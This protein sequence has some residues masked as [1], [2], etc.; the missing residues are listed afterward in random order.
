METNY[1][2]IFGYI[3][4][5]IFMFAVSGLYCRNMY[6]LIVALRTK[7]YEIKTFVRAFGV[8]FIVVGII[9]GLV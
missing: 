7:N 9:M 2:N 4:L 8:V 3:V 5:A 6:K 1:M